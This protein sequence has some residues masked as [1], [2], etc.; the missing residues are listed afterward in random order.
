MDLLFVDQ[1]VLSHV[2]AKIISAPERFL[3]LFAWE[4]N[5]LQVVCFNVILD[6]IAGAF[7][8]AHFAP[9]A[10]PTPVATGIVV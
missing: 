5:S 6:G 3:A 8:S 1:V 9:V 7:F 4:N 10:L 2:L